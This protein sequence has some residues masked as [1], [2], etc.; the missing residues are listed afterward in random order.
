MSAPIWVKGALFVY[1][2]VV[3]SDSI[4]P[5]QRGTHSIA[6]SLNGGPLQWVNDGPVFAGISDTSVEVN[7]AFGYNG[8]YLVRLSGTG[9]TFKTSDYGATWAR[10][11]F[12]GNI[13]LTDVA[14]DGQTLLGINPS[15]QQH[16]R[17][18]DGGQNWTPFTV[19]PNTTRILSAPD[20]TYYA[21]Q[22]DP[23]TNIVKT[24]Y[25][26]APGSQTWA[27]VAVIDP[28]QHPTLTWVTISWDANGKPQH[29]WATEATVIGASF[30]AEA[31][32]H[33]PAS[34]S[35]YTPGIAEHAP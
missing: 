34:S 2:A 23:T 1:T 17:S 15:N 13:T 16:V 29:L 20:G 21:G 11:T 5:F 14:A 30:A 10:L 33:R 35:G 31:A 25:R 26:Q 6:M 27:S 7:A 28:L 4:I 12:A 8:N 3:S 19:P 18:N 24:I 22:V 9:A 32:I